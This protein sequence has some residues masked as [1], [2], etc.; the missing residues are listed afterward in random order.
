MVSKWRIGRRDWVALLKQ[1][2]KEGYEREIPRQVLVKRVSMYF[3]IAKVSMILRMLKDADELGII[4]VL[5]PST[6]EITAEELVK[7]EPV[8]E[9]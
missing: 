4:K 7:E 2:Q 1:M 8:L 3:D 5:S 6:F 9:E